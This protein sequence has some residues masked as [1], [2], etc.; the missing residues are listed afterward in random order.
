MG[1][2]CG[3]MRHPDP[4]SPDVN[5]CGNYKTNPNGRGYTRELIPTDT[6]GSNFTIPD[7]CVPHGPTTLIT[8]ADCCAHSN[9]HRGSYYRNC[10]RRNRFRGN[11]ATVGGIITAVAETADQAVVD[12]LTYKY[13]DQMHNY[14]QKC[15]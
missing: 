2:N 12:N 11:L 9:C 7:Y 15:R 14:C 6:D 8:P 1:N 13:K 10:N 5:Y 3:G 4:K